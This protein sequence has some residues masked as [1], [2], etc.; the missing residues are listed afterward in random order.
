[1]FLKLNANYV[2]DPIWNIFLLWLFCFNFK[3]EKLFQN[4]IKHFVAD[5]LVFFL[6]KMKHFFD[7]F[8]RKC[9]RYV[10][11]RTCGS[12][13]IRTIIWNAIFT[14]SSK[15]F[16][17]VDTNFRSPFL[18]RFIAGNKSLDRVVEIFFWKEWKSFI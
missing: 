7:F 4:C 1:M 8:F 16:F 5:S 15:Y 11:N 9:R 12:G 6:Y 18:F 2:A 10:E 17:L 3:G 13:K 14:F